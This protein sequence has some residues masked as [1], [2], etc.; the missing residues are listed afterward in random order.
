VW[1]ASDPNQISESFAS[2]RN[3]PAR[4]G[5][6]LVFASSLSVGIQAVDG[7]S[8]E[9]IWATETGVRCDRQWSSAIIVGDLVVLPRPDGALHAFDTS[10]GVSVW[11]L[12]PAGP[13]E[14]ATRSNCT[15]PGQQVQGGHEL[16][17][18]VAVAP[19]GTLIVASTSQMIYAI[20]DS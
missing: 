8:G 16:Q 12:A 2:L 13:G 11:R 6:A 20:G 3:S 9:A 19:D 1:Q 7:D 10:T 18:S 17:A 14:V 4:H 5:D 15:I